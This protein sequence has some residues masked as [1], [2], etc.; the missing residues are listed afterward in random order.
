[1]GTA[2]PLFL[3]D[4]APTRHQQFA[5][6]GRMGVAKLLGLMSAAPWTF[7]CATVC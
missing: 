1:M 7:I 3:S 6:D 4:L 5:S 2:M